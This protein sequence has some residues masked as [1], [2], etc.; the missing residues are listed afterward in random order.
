M[1]NDRALADQL[2]RSLDRFEGI[3]AQ[4]QEGR[5]SPAR[6]CSTTQRP[7]EQLDATLATLNKVAQDLQSIHG[8]SGDQRRPAPPPGQ[9]RGVWPRGHRAGPAARRTLERDLHQAL[10]K[11]TGTASKLI[12]DPQIYDAVNDVVI[13]VNES[14]I[15]RWL[16]RNRQKKGIEKRYED[17]KKAI[18]EQGGTPPP[19]DA[20]AGRDRRTGSRRR[21]RRHRRHRRRK[22]A[23]PCHRTSW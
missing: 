19:L 13:G 1:L 6:R 18:E 10:A 23:R 15:L 3:L 20:G 16:I 5:G 14:R 21:R 11:G 12:N 8:R 2:A 17:E 7:S 9:G 4:A 22:G